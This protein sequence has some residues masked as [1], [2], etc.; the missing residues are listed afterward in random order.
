MSQISL[1]SAIVVTERSKRT[2]WRRI[3][4]GHASKVSDSRARPMLR[5]E[6]VAPQIVAPMTEED[7][8]VLVAADSGD[9]A[10]QA[11]IGQLFLAA[12]KLEI[13]QHWLKMAAEHDNPDAMQV[14]ARCY[15]AGE[16]VP[17]DEN[18]AFMWRSKAAAHGHAIAQAQMD[19]IRRGFMT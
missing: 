14:L 7:L 6:D 10:A 3:S 12:G 15:A 17:K 2:W 19:G 16:G 5:L 11:D 8:T 4:D 13:A 1:E 9:A 18:L